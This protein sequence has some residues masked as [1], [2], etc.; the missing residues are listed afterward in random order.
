MKVGLIGTGAIANMHARAYRNIGLSWLPV[1]TKRK[2]AGAISRKSGML[3]FVPSVDDLC[4]YPGLD[5][6]DVC[7]FPDS[8]LRT[9]EVLRGNQT[10]H[11]AAEADCHESGR[12]ARK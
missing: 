11:Y 3:E 4:R 1:R 10:A 2:R 5:Y 12:S 6:V 8:H 7:S 9:G